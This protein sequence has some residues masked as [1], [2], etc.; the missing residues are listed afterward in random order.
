MEG[1]NMTQDKRLI[2]QRKA[3]MDFM[4]AYNIRPSKFLDSERGLRNWWYHQQKLVN[5]GELRAVR[6]E[7]FREILEL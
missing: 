5:I 3:I 6:I 4:E 2:I 1:R 7:M